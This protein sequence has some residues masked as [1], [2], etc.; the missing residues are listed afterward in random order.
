MER[1]KLLGLDKVPYTGGVWTIQHQRLM[2]EGY[3]VFKDG[4]YIRWSPNITAKET[5]DV[6][7][8][9]GSLSNIGFSEKKQLAYAST[10]FSSGT[11]TTL[12]G[13]GWGTHRLFA[14]VE[15][16]ATTATAAA[17]ACPSG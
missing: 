4:T 13:L 11:F 7:K 1:L 8:L 5:Q 9:V 3:L 17:C 12:R 15:E 14:F 6:E 10:T 2:E 16:L